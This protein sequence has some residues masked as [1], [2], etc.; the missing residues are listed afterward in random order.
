MVPSVKSV[1][2]DVD[3]G[4]KPVYRKNEDDSQSIEYRGH[5]ISDRMPI[6]VYSILEICTAYPAP[7][8]HLSHARMLLLVSRDL[9]CHC[10]GHIGDS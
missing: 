6:K 9:A 10:D 8:R 4:I 5:G 1:M 2:G 7:R 3:L